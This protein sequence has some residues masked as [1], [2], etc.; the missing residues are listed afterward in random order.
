VVSLG[1]GWSALNH[2]NGVEQSALKQSDA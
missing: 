1:L 2:A